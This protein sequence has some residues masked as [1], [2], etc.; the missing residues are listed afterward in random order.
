MGTDPSV[1][2]ATVPPLAGVSGATNEAILD[3][4]KATKKKATVALLLDTSSSMQGVAIKNAVEGAAGF[5]DRLHQDD[6]IEAYMF[7]DAVTPLQPSGRAGDTVEKLK[8]VVKMLYADG[9]TALYDAVCTGVERID[10]LREDDEAAGESRLYAVVLLSDGRNTD[11][12]RTENEM[13]ACLPSG[14]HVEEVKVYTIA[15]GDDADR[16]ILDRIAKRT[17]GKMFV[18]TPDNIGEVYK[19]ISAEQ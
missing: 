12:K 6:E 7:S 17:H 14:E 19:D 5:M 10:K 4:F 1:T 15:Y 11:S 3:V 18:G 8:E 9:S 13:F 2:P 16:Q